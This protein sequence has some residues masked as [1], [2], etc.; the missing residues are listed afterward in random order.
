M[1]ILHLHLRADIN[2]FIEVDD[3]FTHK[4]TSIGHFHTPGLVQHL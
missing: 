1:L 2:L 4:I 3:H